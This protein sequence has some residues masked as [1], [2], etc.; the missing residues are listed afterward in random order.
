M[1]FRTAGVY[2]D[3][4]ES[5]AQWD[6]VFEANAI[7]K[8]YQNFTATLARAVD[9]GWTTSKPFHIICCLMSYVS[10]TYRQNPT[11]GSAF[12]FDKR[13]KK[14]FLPIKFFPA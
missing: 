10:A 6:N 4:Y 2:F 14:L 13:W 3:S 8:K 5:G 9:R 7:Y 1:A 12:F 11:S